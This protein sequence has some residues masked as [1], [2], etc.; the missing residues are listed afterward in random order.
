MANINT[1]TFVKIAAEFFIKGYYLVETR[2]E[3]KLQQHQCM[4]TN[5]GKLDKEQN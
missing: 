2:H 3:T 1:N 5:R 4:I